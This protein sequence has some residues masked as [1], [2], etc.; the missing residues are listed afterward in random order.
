MGSSMWGK[1]PKHAQLFL[2]VTAVPTSLVIGLCKG[3]QPRLCRRSTME[4]AVVCVAAVHQVFCCAR[5]PPQFCMCAE[6]E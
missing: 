4:P 1:Y 3:L 6:A 5:Y 2:L